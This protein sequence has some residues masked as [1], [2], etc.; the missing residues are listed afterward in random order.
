MAQSERAAA[1][2]LCTRWPTARFVL[3]L[4]LAASG[5]GQ[6]QKDT[7][8]LVAVTNLKSLHLSAS[9]AKDVS[10]DLWKS[11]LISLSKISVLQMCL[12]YFS[13]LIYC[14]LKNVRLLYRC[15][16]MF[17]HIL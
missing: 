10:E 12:H 15:S 4:P 14:R 9:V 2:Q 7:T 17:I 6:Q 3:L 16:Y 13:N 1:R 5:A 8:P 11:P